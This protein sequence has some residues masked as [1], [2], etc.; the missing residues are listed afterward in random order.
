MTNKDEEYLDKEF[1]KGKTKFRGQAMVL[2]ALARKEGMKKSDW[3]GEKGKYYDL[4]IKKG[5]KEALEDVL[6]IIDNIGFSSNTKEDR[7]A[8]NELITE[9]KKKLKDLK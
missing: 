5:K 6:K 2:L 7:D 4:G 3:R 1:P 8:R 9:I